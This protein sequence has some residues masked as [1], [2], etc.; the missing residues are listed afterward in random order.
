MGIVAG[1]PTSFKDRYAKDAEKL[2]EFG[3]T[4]KQLADL[5]GVTLQTVTNWKKK[6][7]LFFASLKKGKEVSN[8]QVVK[9]LYQRATGY[10]HPEVHISNYQGD[11][12][13]TNIVKHY[14]PSEVACIYWLNNRDPENWRNRKESDESSN[15]YTKLLEAIAG[16]LKSHT[17]PEPVSS[18]Q[19]Q[20]HGTPGGQTIKKDADK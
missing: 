18:G 14:P 11:V 9:S 19:S 15:D 2:C 8:N 10:S 20:V 7:P 4:D 13:I 1:R 6:Y 3:L 5:W 17:N 16:A 12:T